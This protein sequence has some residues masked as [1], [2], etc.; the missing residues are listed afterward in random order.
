[1]VYMFSGASIFNQDLS[2]W[3]VSNVTIMRHMFDGA[4]SFDQDISSWNISNV[5]D[6][7]YMFGEYSLMLSDDN[8]CAIHNSFNSN[9]VWPYDWS[10]FCTLIVNDFAT[11][12]S[13]YTIHQNFPNPFNPMTQINYDLPEDCFVNIT[14]YDVIGHKIKS[15]VK[16]EQEAGFRSAHWNATNELGEPV[17]AGMYIYTIQ[18]GE[19]RQTRKM[20]LLK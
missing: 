17:P 1:M 11:T 13:Q 4:S 20:V 2:S 3:D 10:S 8:K 19:F 9:S 16:V 14:I 18:A 5:T 7:T 15:L 6:M 12:P